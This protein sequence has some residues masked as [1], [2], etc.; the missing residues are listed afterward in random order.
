MMD[1]QDQLTFT[2]SVGVRL[3]EASP[4]AEMEQLRVQIRELDREL[5]ELLAERLRLCIEVGR[6]KRTLG[7]PLR[8]HHVE[9]KVYANARDTAARSGLTPDQAE[10]F[11]RKIVDLAIAAQAA[12]L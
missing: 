6:Y 5:I 4:R 11:M 10:E 7:L 9:A 12:D 3:I 1:L 2:S 8:N